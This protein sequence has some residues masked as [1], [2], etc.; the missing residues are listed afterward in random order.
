ML[1]IFTYDVRD[2]AGAVATAQL[3][4]GIAGAADIAP[5][6]VTAAAD[7]ALVTIS[8]ASALDAAALLSRDVVSNCE[9]MTVTGVAN[10]VGATVALVAGQLVIS[11]AGA[12]A[13][14]DCTITSES[15]VTATGHVD[16]AGLDASAA[17]NRF[18]ASSICA[19]AD[20]LGLGGK[21]VLTG[22]AGA[23][24]LDGGDGNDRLNGGLGADAVI[25]G[26][27]HDV[28]CVDNPLDVVSEAPGEGVD[29][30]NTALARYTLGVDVEKLTKT[31]A[32]NFDGVGNALANAIKGGGGADI[33][34]GRDGKD[35]LI[36]NSGADRV[37]EGAAANI[38]IGGA[39]SNTFVFD[40]LG[41]ASD[42]DVIKDFA[43]GEDVVEISRSVFPP[44]SGRTAGALDAALFAFGT[45]AT[46]ADDHL[47]RNG[48]NGALY[49][50]EDGLG[51]A[52]QVQIAIFSNQALLDADDFMLI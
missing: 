33:P 15:G 4:V 24:H 17:N 36:G 38:M 11:A 50:Y 26:L 41:A 5:P 6:L 32:G 23:D 7:K 51:G 27:G 14:F 1:D 9:S 19:A 40:F 18:R 10:A 44:F 22:A 31:G 52:A 29:T 2:A 8:Q 49:Y 25:G 20:I 39:R 42:R 30:V 12:A 43:A 47:I 21:G 35:V 37:N 28:Y 13:G 45:G 48:A 46:A 16:V 3:S 34:E